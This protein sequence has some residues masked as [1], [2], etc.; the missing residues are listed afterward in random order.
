MTDDI[1]STRRV[2]MEFGWTK[3]QVE[4]R[5]RVRTA[6]DELLPPDWDEVYVPQSYA[7]DVQMEFSR[8]F[9]ARTGQSAG[10]WFHIGRSSTAATMRMIGSTSSWRGNEGGG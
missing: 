9:C 6:L 8:T 10:C 5:E 1:T 2:A 4:Y 7:S 3:E